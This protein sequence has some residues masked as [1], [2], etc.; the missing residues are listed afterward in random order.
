M[1]LCCCDGGGGRERAVCEPEHG[2]SAGRFGAV[3]ER[4]DQWGHAD[5]PAGDEH[6]FGE[7]DG[8]RDGESGELGDGSVECV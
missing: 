4:A 6:E 8:G 3:P 7:H 5:Q 2:R 1:R